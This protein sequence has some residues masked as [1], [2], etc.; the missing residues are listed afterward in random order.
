MAYY[1]LFHQFV[2][3]LCLPENAGRHW[4]QKISNISGTSRNNNAVNSQD[5][6]QIGE[7]TA[8]FLLS[9]TT[10]QYL[11]IRKLQWDYY[12]EVA[13]LQHVPRFPTCGAYVYAV[14]LLTVILKLSTYDGEA[15]LL[16]RVL[17]GFQGI[18]MILSVLYSAPILLWLL[19][20]RVFLW[21]VSTTLLS[22]ALMSIALGSMAAY[23][24][25]QE[26][27]P[28]VQHAGMYQIV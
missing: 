14:V 19:L 12:N 13:R 3:L 7:T 6:K 25:R 2:R 8:L 24:E 17:V 15:I 16:I 28:N 5:G 9:L 4:R 20:S 10:V 23:V 27:L 18:Q 26:P 1:N 22:T 21:S 11:T